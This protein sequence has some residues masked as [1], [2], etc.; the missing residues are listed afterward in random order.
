MRKF[1]LSFAGILPILEVSAY[2]A[3]VSMSLFSGGLSI[4]DSLLYIGIGIALIGVLFLCIAF[5]KPSSKKEEPIESPFDIYLEETTATD[6]KPADVADEEILTSP[7]ETKVS[8]EEIPETTIEEDMVVPEIDLALSKEPIEAVT[9]E[10]DE[11][12][13]TIPESIEESLPAEEPVSEEEHEPE[14]EKIYPK[15]ILTNE[16][17]HDFVILPLYEE[18]TIGRKTDNDLVL[19]DITISGLHCKILYQDGTVF[20]QDENSTNGTLVNGERI[21]EKTELHKGDKIL[22]GK[23][24]FNVSINE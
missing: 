12:P 10:P 23:Q 14:E 4:L 16:K 17:N 13:E 21:Y 5:L 18:T 9:E 6:T 20:I 11:E 7:E 1:L 8:T 2:A 15:L 19:N 24:E 3:P 22:L